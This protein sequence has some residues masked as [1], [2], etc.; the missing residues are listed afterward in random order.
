MSARA[1]LQIPSRDD[2]D[3]LPDPAEAFLTSALDGA[4]RGNGL[5]DLRAG[6]GSGQVNGHAD[7]CKL[8]E[9]LHLEGYLDIA[10]TNGPTGIWGAREDYA[11]RK[12]QRDNGLAIDGVVWPRGETIEAIRGFSQ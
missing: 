8:Q 10:A 9:L 5:F 12:F 1:F 11:L 2:L 6:V 3:C 7:V 4:L